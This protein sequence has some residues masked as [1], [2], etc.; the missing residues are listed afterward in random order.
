MHLSFERDLPVTHRLQACSRY[1]LPYD[2]GCR[3][4]EHYSEEFENPL[5]SELALASLFSILSK[6]WTYRVEDPRAQLRPSPTH[7][8]A[9]GARPCHAE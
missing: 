4:E 7:N 2:L 3:S 8:L 6:E 9:P 1:K 5:F